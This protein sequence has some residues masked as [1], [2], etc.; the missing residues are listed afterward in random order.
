M[1]KYEDQTDPNNSICPD[2]GS[3]SE[4]LIMRPGPGWNNLAGPVWEHTSG[5]RVHVG[6]LVRLPD[7]T[8]I[9]SNKWP[10]AKEAALF[11]KINGGNKKRGLMAWSLSLTS[12]TTSRV[13]GL[14][15]EKV[16]I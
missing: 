10:E 14:R 1:S 2:S 9:T 12:T 6:G 3:T 13:V 11:I 4:R 7:M 5:A 15:C 8:F 16:K